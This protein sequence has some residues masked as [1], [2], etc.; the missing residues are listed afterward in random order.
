MGEN[1]AVSD[2]RRALVLG[3]GGAT[4]IAWELGVLSGLTKG[5]VEVGDAELVV[6][7]S[8]GALVAARLTTDSLDTF[9]ARSAERAGR[10][11][12]PE[13]ARLLAAQLSPSRRH[14][15]AWLG[16]RATRSWTQQAQDDWVGLVAAGLSGLPWPEQL[17][18]V[19]TEVASGRPA[20][21]SASRP[22]DLAAA[23]AASCAV[24]GVFPPVRI[25]G[26]LFFDGGLR[27]PANLDVADS[28][29]RVLAVA[30]L[31]G[32]VRPHRRPAAQAAQLARGGARVVLIEPDA[33]GRRAIGVDVLSASRVGAAHRA[34]EASGRR[35]AAPA[36]AVWT[37]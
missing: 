32:S 29:V 27:S 13:L 7:T 28:A 17:V 9:S 24:P 36:L 14:A 2:F 15:L 5:G 8:A 21:F 23:V 37:R 12:V 33:A 11:G 16:N 3:S 4:G 31:T 20:Y 18:I 19:A 34:G 6:G 26:R 30:P 1:R 10:L 22:V 35:R 25:E